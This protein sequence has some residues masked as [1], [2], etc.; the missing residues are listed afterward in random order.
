MRGCPG[1]SLLAATV[2]FRVESLNLLNHA[3]FAEPGESL[4]ENNFAQIT[5]TLN[6]G[7]AFQFTL[8]LRF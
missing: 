8:Q 5:N 4:S 7:R 2:L 1:Y 6:D 3:Q